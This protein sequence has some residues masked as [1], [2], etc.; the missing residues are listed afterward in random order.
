[1]MKNK[2]PGLMSHDFMRHL[3]T[4][5]NYYMSIM[6]VLIYTWCVDILVCPHFFLFE[7]VGWQG[8]DFM[9]LLEFL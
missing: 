3:V 2:L 5:G 9:N 7:G 4:W 1:M 6:V 8:D